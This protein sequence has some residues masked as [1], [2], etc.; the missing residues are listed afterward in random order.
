MT[1]LEERLKSA[2]DARAE[3]FEASQTAWLEVRRRTPLPPR[4]ARWLLAAVPVVMIA[5]FVPVLLNGGLGRNSANDPDTVYRQLMAELTPLG[6]PVELSEPVEARLWFAKGRMGNPVF[7]MLARRGQE[8]YGSCGGVSALGEGTAEGSLSAEDAATVLDFGL[9]VPEATQVRAVTGDGRRIPGAIHRVAGAPVSIWTVS[10]PAAEQVAKVEF[11]DAGQRVLGEMPREMRSSRREAKPAGPP[12]ELPGA[13]TLRPYLVPNE[14]QPGATD[15]TVIWERG[16]REVSSLSLKARDLWTGGGEEYPVHLQVEDGVVFGAARPDV[17]RIEVSVGGKTLTLTPRPDPWQLNVGVFAQPADVTAEAGSLD[18]TAFDSRGAEVWRSEPE[19][20]EARPSGKRI[21]A[22]ASVPGTEDFALGPV[23]VW[24]EKGHEGVEL[25][26][27]GGVRPDGSQAGG[28][29]SAETDRNTFQR[30]GTVSYLPEPGAELSYGVLPGEAEAVSAVTA[31]GTRLPAAIVPVKGGPAPVWA[32]RYPR[33]TKIA[34]FAFREKG[35][36]LERIVMMD[37]S[38]WKADRPEGAGQALPGGVSAHIS[39]PSCLHFWKDGKAQPG[40]FDR[41]P[42]TT[43]RHVIGKER[44]VQW[45]EAKGVWYGFALAGTAR[46][47]GVSR[48]GRVSA[49]TVP[50]PWGHGVVLFAAPTPEEVTKKGL[51]WP[52]LSLTG[53]AADGSVLWEWKDAGLS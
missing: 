10:F 39:A 30:H 25:C 9:V 17:V 6:D 43:L 33:G 27:S 36:E 50:D 35:R 16:G 49:R 11:V 24:Y 47:E 18:I 31:D 14:T 22:L 52:D 48:T 26:S 2:L 44:P 19:Q 53:Y 5:L 8:P 15:L 20:P 23:Q 42:G 12:Y 1:P 29:S 4:R 41:L 38:C 7:C 28:C 40:S 21:G 3:T 32:V 46:V 37:R 13:L 51:N 45:S 34:A